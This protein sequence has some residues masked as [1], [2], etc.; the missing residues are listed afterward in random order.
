MVM[1]SYVPSIFHMLLHMTNKMLFFMLSAIVCRFR[2]LL[3]LSPGINPNILACDDWDSTRASGCANAI[4][5]TAVV[6][7]RSF[8]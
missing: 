3:S 5:T 2:N 8:D 6:A 1:S 4:A 7:D